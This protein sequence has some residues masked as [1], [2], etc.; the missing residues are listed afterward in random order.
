MIQ[1]FASFLNFFTKLISNYIIRMLVF[2]IILGS[3]IICH[4]LYERFDAEVYFYDES[5]FYFGPISY[6]K[7]TVRDHHK[8][9]AA[10]LLYYGSQMC[11]SPMLWQAF[12]KGLVPLPVTTV[13]VCYFFTPSEEKPHFEL[14]LHHFDSS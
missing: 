12:P 3:I 4:F 9:A 1:A 10:W 13:V 6:K 5:C 11:N 8:A 14:V 7:M 2:V